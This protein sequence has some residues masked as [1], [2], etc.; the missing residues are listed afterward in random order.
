MPKV[1]T[2]QV[3]LRLKPQQPNRNNE[4]PVV[5]SV[6]W[7][8]KKERSTGIR[9]KKEDWDKKNQQ[10]KTS[11]TNSAMLNSLLWKAKDE[12]MRRKQY[13]EMN[14]I[15]YTIDDLLCEVR[16]GDSWDVLVRGLS[17]VRQWSKST[18]R[19]YN[20]SL[21][22][23]RRYDSNIRPTDFDSDR[24]VG[25]AKWMKNQQWTN[26]TVRINLM[27]LQ[28]MLSYAHKKRM[29]ETMPSFEVFKKYKSEEAKRSLS[30][31]QLRLIR[32]YRDTVASRKEQYYLSVYLIA[33]YFQGLALCDMLKIKKSELRIDNQGRLIYQTKRQKTNI[34]VNIT[35]DCNSRG[36]WS[37]FSYLSEKSKGD[38]LINCYKGGEDEDLLDHRRRRFTGT[39]NSVLKV[40]AEKANR[41]EVEGCEFVDDYPPNLSY[42]SIRHSFATNYIYNRGNPFHLASLMGRSESGIS[43]YVKSLTSMDEI[44]KEKQIVQFPD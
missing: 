20:Q 11:V 2:A 35:C 18:F 3:A 28:G 5:L 41:G 44:M 16:E 38:Y 26:N 27:C 7:N 8:G 24:V 40:F 31:E 4:Y 37:L 23:L 14:N 13:F 12:V 30:I 17:E 19:I 42:Y 32:S 43:R 29:I 15:A 36:F 25:Y 39:M 6:A 1:T 9:C 21:R 34:P 33:Y 10:I 22:V